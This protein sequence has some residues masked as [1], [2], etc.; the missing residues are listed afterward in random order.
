MKFILIFTF[1]IFS[2]SVEALEL[3]GDITQGSLIIGKEDPNRIIFINNIKTKLSKDGFFVFAINYNQKGNIIIK[4]VDKNNQI[5]TKSYK[6]KSRIFKT[7]KIDGLAENLVT[8]DEESLKQI[9]VE[10]KLIESA[11]NEDTDYTFFNLGF[12]KPVESARISGVYGSRRILNGQ[13][14]SPHL[15]VDFAAPKGTEVKASCDG[16]VSLVEDNFYYAGK[17]IILDHGQGVSTFYGHLS[18]IIRI[19][20]GDFVK[21]GQVIGKVGAS[22]RATGPHLHFGVSVFETKVDPQ[23]LLK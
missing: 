12:L 15:G 9:K 22:G 21:K 16:Y 11:L 3:K 20:K 6:I 14:R 17:T 18:D 1:L 4:S 8:P 19:H 13:V 5:E 10:Q 23:L 2:H 7:E